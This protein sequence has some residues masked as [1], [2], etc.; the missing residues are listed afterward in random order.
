[1]Y[2]NILLPTDGSRGMASAAAHA[3]DLAAQNDAT[4]HALYVVDLRSYLLLPDET[5]GRV[6][7]LLFEEGERA[8]DA[9]SARAEDAGVDIVTEVREGVPSEAILE[10]ARER[11]VD[12]VVM[13]THGRTGEEKR[14]LGSVAEEVVRSSEVPVLTVRMNEEDAVELEDVVPEEQERYIA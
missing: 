3:F 10:Y 9:L 13:G 5:K 11:G 12:L 1:M 7:E 14:I 2:A 4:V 8:L 6:R